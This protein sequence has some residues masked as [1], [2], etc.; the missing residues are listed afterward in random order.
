MRKSDLT[1]N[2][3]AFPEI[4]GKHAQAKRGAA[5]LNLI[6]PRK[7]QTEELC[8][9]APGLTFFGQDFSE[10]FPVTMHGTKLC[11][12]AKNTEQTRTLA[13]AEKEEDAEDG[14]LQMHDGSIAGKAL[15]EVESRE[16]MHPPTDCCGE[17]RTR[18]Y[19][20]TRNLSYLLMTNST[21]Y[22]KLDHNT[23]KARRCGGALRFRNQI[24]LR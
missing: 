8:R 19:N 21:E 22:L 15:I 1:R 6:D 7:Q 10:D 17:S 12:F 3:G 14:R 24:T 4:P 23:A 20:R 16:Y 2:S 13:A 11:E 9:T 18:H 5:E